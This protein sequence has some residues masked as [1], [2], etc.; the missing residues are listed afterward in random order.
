M[1]GLVL[2]TP[3]LPS[4][5]DVKFGI[6]K[7]KSRLVINDKIRPCEEQGSARICI[8]PSTLYLCIFSLESE[9]FSV[10]FEISTFEFV[11][12]VF[13]THTINIGIGSIVF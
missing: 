2:N 5:M 12:N 6:I 7:T 10:I 8:G 3:Y 1:F 13:L 4:L 11:K 9:N